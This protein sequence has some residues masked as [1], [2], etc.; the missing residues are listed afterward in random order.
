MKSVLAYL[1]NSRKRNNENSGL[2]DF[3]CLFTFMGGNFSL[4][5][6]KVT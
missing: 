1:N 3:V 4:A 2:L 5:V 6:P